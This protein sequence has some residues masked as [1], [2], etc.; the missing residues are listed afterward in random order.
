MN[1]RRVGIVLPVA[2]KADG[3]AFGRRCIDALIVYGDIEPI[4]P[5]IEALL[6]GAGIVGATALS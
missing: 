2:G 3:R 6:P 4:A 1:L 5:E